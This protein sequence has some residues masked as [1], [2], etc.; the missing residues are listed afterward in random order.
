MASI[1]TGFAKWLCMEH[2]LCT[3]SLSHGIDTVSMYCGMTSNEI[4]LDSNPIVVSWAT[5]I[6]KLYL[7]L[8][9]EVLIVT[10]L[11]QGQTY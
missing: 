4:G 2:V 7:Q 5:F 1:T 8:H 10:Y 3:W 11:T 6:K 9:D